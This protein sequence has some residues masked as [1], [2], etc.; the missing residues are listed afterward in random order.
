MRGR[1]S[2]CGE[3][4]LLGN[5]CVLSQVLGLEN[6]HHFLSLLQETWLLIKPRDSSHSFNNIHRPRV[7]REG[8]EVKSIGCS[9]RG[10]GF[11]S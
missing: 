9:S 5:G 8:R 4:R 11:D 2:L 7:W 1:Q 6:S 3:V 10:P